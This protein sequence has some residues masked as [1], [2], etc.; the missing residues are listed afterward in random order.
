MASER[1]AQE[2]L[3]S[4]GFLKT[5]VVPALLIFLVPIL[6]FLFFTHAQRRFD[7]EAREAILESIRSDKTLTD[8][9][10]AKATAFF[11]ANPV[12]Q[13]LLHEQFAALGT[14]ESRFYY[15]T[16]RWMILL[17]ALSVL[18]G[19][20]VFLLVGVCVLFSLGSQLAQYLSLSAGW[21][22]LRIYGALQTLVQGVLLVALSFWVPA[23]WFERYSVK[24][25][26]VTGF[27][28]VVAVGLVIAAIF[29]RPK[30]DFQLDGNVIPRDAAEP[31][32]HA[33]RAICDRVGTTPPDQ[34]IVGI[35][36]NFFVTEH[37]VIVQ[38]N[39]LRGRTLFVSLS[40]LKQLHGAEAE[41]V[42]A[43]EMAH[44]SGNDTL[45]SKRISPLLTCYGSY[46]QTL[47][48]GGVTMPVFYFMLCFRALYQLSLGRLSR[49]RE[50]RADRIAVESTSPRDF[51]GALLRIVAYARYR[52]TVQKDLF[53]NERALESANISERIEQGFP[54]YAVSLASN[55]DLGSQETSHP[56]DSH[57][58]LSERLDAIGMPL[59]SSG[60]QSLL[61]MP[62]DG[63]WYYLIPNVAQLERQEWDNFEAQF[64]KYHEDTLPYRF[65]PETPEELA[66]VTQSFPELVF[67]T[68]DGSLVLDHEKLHY[69]KWPEPVPFREITG[70]VLADNAVLQVNRKGKRRQDIKMKVFGRQQ[71][72]VL[73]A[74]NRYY[75]RYMAAVEYQ[76]Q[77]KLK[78]E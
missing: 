25:I 75:V 41:A 1:N 5:F 37:P 26:F 62:G 2:A 58:P 3:S 31:L 68:K 18:A 64:R 7:N 78:A 48:E 39:T 42:L 10:R 17:S 33:L 71:Q 13:L 73:Q 52:Q 46:L 38:G 12:S 76:S 72:E 60:P 65:L 36:D 22:V 29:K 45:Y 19:I 24:L 4:F 27:L 74:I 47:H 21:H 8:E 53:D 23:L 16:F 49:Q 11:T 6:S 9:Q 35:D 40:L 43:H 32:W 15:A 57:P 50:R 61:A 59:G 44:F 28:A 34:V 69:A 54:Q 63:R 14:P 51:A 30:T 56:F 67:E 70:F 55:L 20:G 77:K 66:I